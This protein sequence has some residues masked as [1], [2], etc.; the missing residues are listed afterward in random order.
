MLGSVGACP[1]RPR[2]GRACRLQGAHKNQL[3]Y[4]QNH[5]QDYQNRFKSCPGG[6]PGCPGDAPGAP[7]PVLEVLEPPRGGRG[8]LKGHEAVVEEAVVEEAVAEEAVV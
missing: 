7:G 1:Y 6:A 3:E 2:V 8:A 5:P 4:H